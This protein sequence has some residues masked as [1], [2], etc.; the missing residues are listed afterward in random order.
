MLVLSKPPYVYAFET[1]FPFTVI[2]APLRVTCYN[3]DDENL[4]SFLVIFAYFFLTFESVTVLKIRYYLIIQITYNRTA[5][6]DFIIGLSINT[7]VK[8]FV[9]RQK[10]YKLPTIR[11]KKGK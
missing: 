9:K 5:F 1:P 3:A 4:T 2:G 11:G 6:V 8:V 10:L 7:D